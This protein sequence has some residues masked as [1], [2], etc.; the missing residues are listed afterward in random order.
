MPDGPLNGITVVDLT[1][2]LAGP[3]CTMV[4]SDL[5]AR[6]IKVEPPGVGDDSRGIGPFVKVPV[7]NDTESDGNPASSPSSS[8]PS[9]PEMADMSAYFMS[10]NRAKESIA[11]DLKS[12]AD[13]DVFEALLARADVLVEN[14]RP[15]TMDKLGYGWDWAHAR[16]P[17]L[18][19]AAASGFGQTGPYARRPAYDMV[20]QGMGGVMSITGHEDGPPTR[21]GTSIGD[22]TAGL[23]TAI[24]INAALYH[25]TLSGQGMMIDVAMLDSQVAILENALARYQ[26]TGTVPGPI[27]ARHPSITPFEALAT[28][29]GYVIVA[30]GNEGLFGVLCRAIGRDELAADPRFASNHLRTENHGALKP[31][32]EAALAGQPTAHWLAVFEDA[33]VPAAPINDVA[34]VMADPQVLARNMVVPVEGLP[35]GGV[36]GGDGSGRGSAGSGGGADGGAVGGADGGGAAAADGGAGANP[37]LRVSGNPI[38]LSAFADPPTRGAPRLLDADR[39]AI[40]AEL[41]ALAG[42]GGGG[43]AKK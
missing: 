4:L 36:D 2:V 8:S 34:Q 18:I 40:L 14:Y 3:Y 41:A 38:K 23:F 24:G 9:P 10:L 39:A 13:R 35:G 28:A 27:G 15:G 29:D 7:P 26:A 11:I 16:F 5:G 30:A 33:G 12:E 19:Y 21:V 22:I 32:I 25:R 42:D 20:V 37:P 17:R 31:L 43:G 1:R 6:V